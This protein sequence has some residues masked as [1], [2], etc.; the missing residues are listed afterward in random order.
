MLYSVTDPDL[1]AHVANPNGWDI[2]FGAL[3]DATCGGAGLSPCTLAHEIERYESATGKLVAW[4]RLPSVNGV[5]SSSDTVIYIYYGNISISSPT[6]NKNGVWDSNFMEVWHLGETSGAPLDSTSHNY[7][8][9]IQTPGNVTQNATGNN[10]P[11][12]HFS[13]S[14]ANPSWLTLTDGTIAANAPYSIETW[15][16][17]DTTV[18]TYFVG[19]ATKDRDTANPDSTANWGGVWTDSGGKNTFGSIYNKGADLKGSTFSAAQWYHSVAVFDGGLRTLYLNGQRDSNSLPSSPTVY[20]ADMIMPVRVNNDVNNNSITGVFDEVR[21]STVVRSPGWILTSYKNMD[22]PGNIGSP[23]FYAVGSEEGSVFEYKRKITLNCS[24]KGASCGAG[25]LSNFPVLIDTTNWLQADKDKLKTVAY[26]GHVYHPY[27]Y[28]IIFRDS[29]EE[30]QI[31][32]EIEKYEDST[33]T[34]IAWVRSTSFQ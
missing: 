21:V 24:A 17:I 6:A 28:D 27:G 13:G 14:E 5:A 18:P 31:P 19:L 8:G 32:H 2:I 26:S 30:T 7:S 34:L 16:Y 12:Y 23:G 29:S 9:T 4:I 25:G 3:D 11:A 1:H 33:G 22:D 10:T 20:L 15:L